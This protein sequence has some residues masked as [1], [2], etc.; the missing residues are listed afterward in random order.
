[1]NFRLCCMP[2]LLLFLFQFV[3]SIEWWMSDK[4]DG[5]KEKHINI[6]TMTDTHTHTHTRTL[7]MPAQIDTMIWPSG[8]VHSHTRTRTPKIVFCYF[9]WCFYCSWL[10]FQRLID[11]IAHQIA[12]CRF[13]INRLLKPVVNVL[14]SS[15]SH[16]THS[17]CVYF[18]WMFLS[19]WMMHIYGHFECI[20]KYE[21]FSRERREKKTEMKINRKYFCSI[22]QFH[23]LFVF[24]VRPVNLSTFCWTRQQLMWWNPEISQPLCVFCVIE[25]PHLCRRVR[26]RKHIPKNP[27]RNWFQT[28]CI[29]IYME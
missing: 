12:G 15:H 22:S 5:K 3:V 14:F 13:N 1:M 10:K 11:K 21:R 17:Q 2:V 25:R 28:Q 27:K 9:D 18:V 7:W 4:L 29:H 8:R 6:S 26:S 20:V 24:S 19:L 23:A 16:S